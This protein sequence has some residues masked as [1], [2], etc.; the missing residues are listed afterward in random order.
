MENNLNS[1]MGNMVAE[2]YASRGRANVRIIISLV[3]ALLCVAVGV[4][5]LAW[6]ID[7]LDEYSLYTGLLLLALGVGFLVWG[8]RAKSNKTQVFEN[9]IIHTRRKN[10]RTISFEGIKGLTKETED[11]WKSIFVGGLIG[12]LFF[13]DG[14]NIL[15]L[16]SVSG[17]TVDIKGSHVHKF[18]KAKTA[19]EEAYGQYVLRNLTQDN[20]NTVTLM[21]TDRLELANGVLSTSTGLIRSTP[22]V[23]PLTEIVKVEN[24]KARAFRF[25]GKDETGAETEIFKIAAA[26]LYNRQVFARVLELA[27]HP[28]AR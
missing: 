17:P 22:V 24:E 11:G 16:H 25:I 15:R 26:D 28:V 14:S 8:L 20:I 21:L 4:L 2:F 5:L 7:D 12:A 19:I 1:T 9:G 23:L 13:G 27:G 6:W 3:L 10:V 18:K